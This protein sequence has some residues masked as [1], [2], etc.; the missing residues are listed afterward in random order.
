MSIWIPPPHAFASWWSPAI[1]WVPHPPLFQ[2]ARRSP[3]NASSAQLL[4][5]RLCRKRGREPELSIGRQRPLFCAS[6]SSCRTH[7]THHDDSV[8]CEHSLLFG[9]SGDGR[10]TICRKT[11]T[12][13]YSM[14]SQPFTSAPNWVASNSD[15]SHLSI[16]LS[17]IMCSYRLRE[18]RSLAWCPKVSGCA[19]TGRQRS[20]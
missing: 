17:F 14:W 15:D 7:Q 19:A 20:L 5:W 9:H 6:I 10:R 8:S 18:F 13:T 4:R 1:N 12:P 3:Q 2:P 11:F 16:W